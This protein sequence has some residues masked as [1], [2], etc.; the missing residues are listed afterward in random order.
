M[1]RSSLCL[2]A[3]LLAVGSVVAFPLVMSTFGLQA[4]TSTA[5]WLVRWPALFIIVMLALSVLYRFGPSHE[6]RRWRI[7]TPGILFAALAWLAGSAGLSF[8][9]SNFADYNATYGSLGAAIGLMTWMWLTTIVVLVG[10]ELDSEIEKPAP[11]PAMP[12][13]IPP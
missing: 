8:Y 5:T 13:S 11:E 2:L 4:V 3:L 12:R 9:L 1:R 7:L 10:A 6:N